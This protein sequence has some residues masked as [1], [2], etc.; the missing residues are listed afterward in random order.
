MLK[1]AAQ[2]NFEIAHQHKQK[3]KDMLKQLSMKMMHICFDLHSKIIKNQHANL[4][5]L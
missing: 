2:P 1:I 3:F 5:L 4:L